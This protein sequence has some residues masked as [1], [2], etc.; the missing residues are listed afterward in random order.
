MQR[1]NNLIFI[2]NFVFPKKRILTLSL[3]SKVCH[4][5]CNG[6]SALCTSPSVS[7]PDQFLLLIHIHRRGTLRHADS[8]D[9]RVKTIWMKCPCGNLD[10]ISEPLLHGLLE[11]WGQQALDGFWGAVRTRGWS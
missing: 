4:F 1:K 10:A 9:T 8:F 11:L 7:K 6:T 5:V 2:I 3:Q